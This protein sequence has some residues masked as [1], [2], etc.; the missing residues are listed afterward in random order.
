MVLTINKHINTPLNILV[1]CQGL[2]LKYFSNILW[3]ILVLLARG[4]GKTGTI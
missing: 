2:N 4:T 3:G 1:K